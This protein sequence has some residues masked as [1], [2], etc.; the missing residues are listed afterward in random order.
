MV[1][2]NTF[3]VLGLA[4]QRYQILLHVLAGYERNVLNTKRLENVFFEVRVKPETADAFNNDAGPVDIDLI[5]SETTTVKNIG[6]EVPHIPTSNQ[7]GSPTAFPLR[8]QD[9]R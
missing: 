9:P 8:P 4:R 3:S 1:R 6:K 5:K 7:A 2:I